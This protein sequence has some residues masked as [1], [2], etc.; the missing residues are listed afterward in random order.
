MWSFSH[1]KSLRSVI[2]TLSELNHLNCAITLI[3][4]NTFKVVYQD[5]SAN[6]FN[7]NTNYFP[8]LPTEI[9][10]PIVSLYL[11]LEAKKEHCNSIGEQNSI[12]ELQLYLQSICHLARTTYSASSIRIENQLMLEKLIRKSFSLDKQL[13]AIAKH[14]N[15]L[16]STDTQMMKQMDLIMKVLSRENARL[17]NW[18]R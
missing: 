18:S 1:F 4:I 14:Y 7:M 11:I 9:A 2:Y 12:L 15:W 5:S 8:E 17:S 16:K 3:F 10:N 13:E 6:R